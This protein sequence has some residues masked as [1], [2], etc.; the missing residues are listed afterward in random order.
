MSALQATA[1]VIGIAGG[2]LLAGSVRW[3]VR[4]MREEAAHRRA[5]QWRADERA[6]RLA[7]LRAAERSY[8]TEHPGRP[9]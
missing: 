7:E 9:E 2:V 3:I 8:L 1:L 5:Q 6:R 4:D